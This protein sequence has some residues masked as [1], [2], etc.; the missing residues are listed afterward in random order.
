MP[1]LTDAA[2]AIPNVQGLPASGTDVPQMQQLVGSGAEGPLVARLYRPALAKDTPVIL[3]FVGGTWVTGT[4]DTYDET[5][6]EL[7]ARTGWVVVSL[8]TRLAPEATF[9]AAHDDAFALYQWARAHLREWGAD[10]TRV[11]LA[12]EG[13]G[14]DLAISTA[15]LARDR[16]DAGSPTP[17]PDH[18]LL[19]TPVVGTEL[20]YA[21]HERKRPQPAAHACDGGLGAMDLCQA[22]PR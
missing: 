22:S 12:G 17:A 6:R 20:E 7:S 11:A 10:P 16:A 9:P 1:S 3:Y 19:I 14:A 15:L 8:R 13:A 4:L 5:A 18:L 21:Q 2:R